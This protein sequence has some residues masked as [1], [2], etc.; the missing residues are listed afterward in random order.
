MHE[1]SERMTPKS[2]VPEKPDLY[3]VAEFSRPSIGAKVF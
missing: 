2:K 1:N 3:S